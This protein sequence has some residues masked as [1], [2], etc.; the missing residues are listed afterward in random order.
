MEPDK[1]KEHWLTTGLKDGKRSNYSSVNNGV[2]FDDNKNITLYSGWEPLNNQYKITFDANGGKVSAKEMY[3]NT[4]DKFKD[5]PTPTKE[6]YIF[7]G[8]YS[9]KSDFFDERY[10]KTTYKLDSSITSDYNKLREHWLTVGMKEGKKGS[11][12]SVT[13]GVEF[14]ENDDITLYA[15]WVK[16]KIEGKLKYEKNEMYYYDSYFY[17]TSEEYDSHLASLSMLMTKFSMNADG[18]D[19]E[20]DT[21]W[22][23]NQ[24]KRIKGFF[25]TIGFEDFEANEDYKKRTAFNTIGVAIAS[26]QIDD[27][28]IIGIVPRS[29]GYFLEWGNNMWLGDGSKSDYMHEGWYNAANKLIDFL[30]SNLK[31]K[32]ITGDIKVWISGYSRGGATANLA[33]GILDNKIGNSA[34]KFSNGARLTRNNLYAYT[35]EAPMGA[36]INSKKVKAPKDKIYNN[37]FNIIN[38]N[39]LVPKVAMHEWGFT[40]FGIDKFTT[41]EFFDPNNYSNYKTTYN[42][43]YKKNGITDAYKA[44]KLDMYGISGEHYFAA[45]MPIGIAIETIMSVYKGELNFVEPDTRKKNYDGNVLATI[46]LEE[47]VK[48]VGSRK[49]YVKEYQTALREILLIVMNDASKDRTNRIAKL[50]ETLIMGAILKVSGV[51]SITSGFSEIFSKIFGKTISKET[52][53]PLLSLLV[54]VYT[55]RP[56]EIV[57]FLKYASDIFQNHDTDV[58]VTH[59]EAHDSYYIDNYNKTSS[60]KIKTQKLRDNADM[61]RLEFLN[62]N[63][64]SVTKN[65]VE[66]VKIQGKL[67]GKSD[68]NTC[69]KGYACG[70]Y[71]Y[72]EDE[73][74]EVFLPS[75]NNVTQYTIKFKDYSKKPIHTCHLTV[76]TVYSSISSSNEYKKKIYTFDSLE[77]FNSD[78]YTKN[79]AL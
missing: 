75:S 44:D 4:G 49:D 56:N 78:E 72:I 73:K 58:S 30:D 47:V 5:L 62:F 25:D 52:Y 33:A 29:G 57:T 8:W 24:S 74:M 38:P 70:Y 53:T 60:T 32:N 23:K 9:D 10:Y 36:N 2:V 19:S 27:Y 59:V 31:M 63:T 61:A 68:V 22:Y 35:F 15:Q 71:S 55:E 7:Y 20:N 65:G 67:A 13:N 46:V 69:K 26:R 12:S 45:T 18:P 3:I 6:G 76:S 41:T 37:I 14:E 40:R 42:A 48:S 54:S 64:V 17:H 34:Y 21:N 1:L 28:T 43:L 39:D 11:Y 66:N 79:L 51:D 16:I 50:V 77:G